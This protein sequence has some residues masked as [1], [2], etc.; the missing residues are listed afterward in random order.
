MSTKGFLKIQIIFR[1]IGILPLRL[2]IQT[3]STGSETLNVIFSKLTFSNDTHDFSLDS[4][5]IYNIFREIYGLVYVCN[6]TYPQQPK[7]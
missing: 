3:G 4:F 7:E 6:Y 1:D 5:T 2:D